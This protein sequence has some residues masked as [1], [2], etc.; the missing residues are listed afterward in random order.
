M[1]HR[2]AI[3]AVLPA[4]NEEANLERTIRELVAVLSPTC[5]QF[6]VLVVDDGSTDRTAAVAAGVA[7]TVPGV[8]LLH[9]PRN[10]GYGAA[11][12]TGFAAATCEWIL[13]LD[14]D[15]QF[16][17]KE[18]D[19]FLERVPEADLIL[20]YREKRADA[21]YRRMY[22]AIWSTLMRWLLG[23]HVRDLN[24]GFKLMRKATVQSLTLQSHGAF[25]STEF[26][27]KARQ[28]GARTVEVPVT[29]R[30]RMHGR[31]TGG[32]LRV[33]VG[34]FHELGKLWWKIRRVSST[35][36]SIPKS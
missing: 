2:L 22:A 25:I 30:P 10:L 13:L 31:Q 20:G 36:Q 26:L 4:Y 34:A 21:V 6:E 24:C 19:R 17:S 18:V 35:A 29:H 5:A 28:R 8:A 3:S 15:G 14:A 32:D 16:L 11:L 12:R 23:V 33:L 9:H 1:N 7:A 27:A